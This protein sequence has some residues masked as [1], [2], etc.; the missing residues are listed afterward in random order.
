MVLVNT[1][2]EKMCC[3]VEKMEVEFAFDFGNKNTT[4]NNIDNESCSNLQIFEEVYQKTKQ[5]VFQVLYSD[6]NFQ[7]IIK[8]DQEKKVRD[9]YDV[10][11]KKIDISYKNYLIFGKINDNELYIDLDLELPVVQIKSKQLSIKKRVFI[12]QI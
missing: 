1:D 8:I 9:L 5:M 4:L 12:D 3:F 11:R 6:K 10:I 7:C 2:I